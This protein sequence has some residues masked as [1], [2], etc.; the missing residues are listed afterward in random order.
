M[1]TSIS[2]VIEPLLKRQLFHTEQE[3]VRELLREYLWR[4]ISELQRK[5]EQFSHQYGMAFSQ[6]G[7]YLHARSVLLQSEELS[8]EQRQLLGRAVMQE[9]DDWL[10]W[11][12]AIEMLE[13]WLGIR[14]EVFS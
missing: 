8:L 5:N 2:A 3:A 12:V 6:F 10:D 7:E 14:Q 4:Q 11:K 1:S 9:E 13:N